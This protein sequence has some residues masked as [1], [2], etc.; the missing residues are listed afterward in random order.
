MINPKNT[1]RVFN[2]RWPVV[3]LLIPCLAWKNTLILSFHNQ[4]LLTCFCHIQ[5]S[6]RP[7]ED[8]L[9]I[10][11]QSINVVACALSDRLPDVIKISL[12]PLPVLTLL[13]RASGSGEFPHYLCQ[14]CIPYHDHSHR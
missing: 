11:W 5:I 6:H 1:R 9:A 2:I 14:R 10:R 7:S 13:S 3:R 12:P 8:P 4:H